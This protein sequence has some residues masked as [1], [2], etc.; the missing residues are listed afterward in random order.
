MWVRAVW[1]EG[2]REEE[3]VVPETWIKGGYLFWPPGV[4]ARKAREKKISP[5][6]TWR[7]FELIKIK[8]KSANMKECENYDQTTTVESSEEEDDD[9]IKRKRKK[10]TYE[11]FV[12]GHESSHLSEECHGERPGKKQKALP[13]E[14]HL[15][16]PP[17]KVTGRIEDKS[18]AKTG[19]RARSSS[20]SFNLSQ[21][22]SASKR[23]RSISSGDS[24][25]Q[26]HSVRSRSVSPTCFTSQSV[27]SKSRSRSRSS[28]MSRPLSL[29]RRSG[30][31]ESV[32]ESPVLH[33]S[34]SRSA[35][36][37]QSRSRSP[38]TLRKRTYVEHFGS[39]SRSRSRSSEMSRP[40]SLSRGGGNSESVRESLRHRSRSR[41]KN[42]TRSRSKYPNAS[43]SRRSRSNSIERSYS[44]PSSRLVRSRSSSQER[45][46]RYAQ[47]HSYHSFSQPLERSR[48]RSYD[49]I[50]HSSPIK[51]RTAESST[52]SQKLCRTDSQRKRSVSPLRSPMNPR[53]K[54]PTVCDGQRSELYRPAKEDGSKFPMPEGRFQRRVLF[55]LSDLK[56]EILS[57]KHEKRRSESDIGSGEIH[58]AETM[59]EFKEL[60]EKIKVPE[61]RVK[62]VKTLSTI[63]GLNM[64]D[65]VRKIMD[66]LMSNE[67]MSKYNMNGNKHKM[68]FKASSVC[69]L[70][71]SSVMRSQVGDGQVSNITEHDVE[72]AIMVCLKY[73]PD[74]R[75]GGGRKKNVN[76][77]S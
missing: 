60:E 71:K 18:T 31:S 28:E 15:P 33:R 27:G 77:D 1:M 42:K 22:V 36:K 6:S 49:R 38:N 56:S 34:R 21:T 19:E 73:A 29:S 39:K 9:I 17:K 53:S 44:Q 52:R 4:D 37:N 58:Q 26:I 23:S 43:R 51:E 64:R 74:R 62:M 20:D 61:Q 24:D 8:C 40:L 13:D 54:T 75:G 72:N 10:K 41:S 67:L 68:S 66:R 46:E 30:N 32:R 2:D 55:L 12:T 59:E 7:K 70:V 57:L 50:R 69:G 35:N 45:F 5:Q 16:D 11:D 14:V 25:L 48:S 47:R 65:N 76:L 63:G 3:G